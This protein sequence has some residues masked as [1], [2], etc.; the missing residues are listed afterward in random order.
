MRPLRS[1][2][3]PTEITLFDCLHPDLL[4]YIIAIKLRRSDA[5]LP[6]VDVEGSLELATLTAISRMRG[7]MVSYMNSVGLYT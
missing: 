6:P 7:Q 3:T 2:G 5:V 4:L 1:L